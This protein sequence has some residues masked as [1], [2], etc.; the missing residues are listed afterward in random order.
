MKGSSHKYCF[1]VVATAAIFFG[2]SVNSALAGDHIPGLDVSLEQIPGG[3]KGRANTDKDGRFSFSGLQPGRYVLRVLPLQTRTVNH[4]S[5][6]SNTAHSVNPGG[7][8]VH[9]VSIELLPY[10]RRLGSANDE[11]IEILISARQGGRVTGQLTRQSVA[12]RK[13]GAN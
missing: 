4:N 1:L 10:D 12:I 8:E 7:D 6:R 2:F 3:V 13:K 5:S 11:L 9:N